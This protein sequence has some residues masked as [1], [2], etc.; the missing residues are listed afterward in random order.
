MLRCIALTALS[1][2]STQSLQ[3][4]DNLN[5]SLFSYDSVLLSPKMSYVLCSWPCS[6]GSHTTFRTGSDGHASTTTLTSSSL[7]IPVTESYRPVLRLP[8]YDG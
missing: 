4:G 8:G 3:A 1:A 5:I 6:L 2:K 7:T